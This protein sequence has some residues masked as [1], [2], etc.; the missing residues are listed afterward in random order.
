MVV[1]SDMNSRISRTCVQDASLLSLTPSAAETAR[2]DA[3][4]P[5]KPASSTI[6]ADRPLWAS[7]RKESSGEVSSRRSCAAFDRGVGAILSAGLAP[8][9]M[10]ALHSSQ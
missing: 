8:V 9:V 3:Q 7:M 6:F 1:A 5:R 2:P 10:A 4:M